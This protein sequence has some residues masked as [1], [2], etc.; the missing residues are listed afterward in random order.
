[1]VEQTVKLDMQDFVNDQKED[2]PIPKKKKEPLG[3][4]LSVEPED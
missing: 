1:M 3:A 2:S 4:H